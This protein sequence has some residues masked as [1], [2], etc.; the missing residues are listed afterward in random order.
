MLCK[1]VKIHFS[2]DEND[3]EKG[4]NIVFPLHPVP[5]RT[6]MLFESY[7][8]YMHVSVSIYLKDTFKQAH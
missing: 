4:H 7:I 6:I 3:P 8:I 2:L 5:V 1:L